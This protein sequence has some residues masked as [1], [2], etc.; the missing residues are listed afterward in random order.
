MEHY[1]YL[2]VQLLQA[3]KA[4]HQVDE[5][6]NAKRRNIDSQTPDAAHH[7]NEANGAQF[8]HQTHV[9]FFCE[10]AGSPGMHYPLRITS[11]PLEKEK[12]T[13]HPAPHKLQ[14]HQL[15]QRT[16]QNF[17]FEGKAPRSFDPPICRCA[18]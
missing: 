15:T 18:S 14:G 11:R 17:E 16:L 9:I 12:N 2:D 3:R 6:I 8:L 10:G 5:H 13:T 4:S 7:C 1:C